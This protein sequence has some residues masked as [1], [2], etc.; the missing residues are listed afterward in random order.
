L[1]ASV[2]VTATVDRGSAGTV[3]DAQPDAL[4]SSRLYRWGVWVARHRRFVLIAG[5]F[6]LVLGTIL[7]PVLERALG[8]ANYQVQGSE[9]THAEQLLEQRFP[10]LGSEDDALVFYSRNRLASE[11]VY[12]RAIASVIA[13][14]RHQKHVLGVLGPYDVNAV[15]QIS[16]SEHAAITV[17]ALSGSIKQRFE[18]SRRLQAVATRAAGGSGVQTWLTGFSPL[19]RDLSDLGKTDTLRAETIGLPVALLILL[20]AVGSVVAAVLPI[21]MALAGLTLTYG[22]LA[23]L[24][25]TFR[26]DSGLL[27]IVTMIGLGIGIDYSLFVVSRFREHLVERPDA[28]DREES[29]RVADAVGMAIA[30]SGR[31]ILFSGAI[32]AVSLATMYLVHASTFQ[33]LAVGAVVVVVCML[34]TAMTLLP[35]G[36]A[37]LGFRIDRG[38]LPVRLRPANLRTGP[39]R[40]GWWAKWA[41]LMM[42]RPIV[43]AT[44][45]T[46]LLIVAALPALHLHYGVNLG[47]LQA[48]NTPSGKGE[49]VLAQSFSPGAMSPIQVVLNGGGPNSRPGPPVAAAQAMSEVL[50]RDNRVTATIERQSKSS[51]LL[52]VVPSVPIDTAA[53][54][55]LV[56]HIR[57]DLASRARAMG[58]TVF[59]G[60]LTAQTI[61][62]SNELRAKLPLI[63]A[64]IL[65][66]SFLLLLMVFR[67][68][69][70]PVKAIVM[71]LL[72][73]GAT[74]GIVVFVFQD[75]HGQHLLNFTGTGFIQSFLPL[76]VFAILFGLS[77]DYEVFLIGR[78]R[79]EWMKTHDNRLAVAT[80]IEHTARPITAAAAI[81]VAVFGCF[82][83]VNLLELKQIGFALAV[84][85]A[86]DATLIR[87]VLVPATMRLL[88]AWNW[89]LPTRLA[90]VLPGHED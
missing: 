21:L 62:L 2:G 73:I 35:A 34:F 33:E 48:S 50:E 14:M 27:A 31:T 45:A 1:G 22:V 40:Q 80:G 46:A 69:L 53:A 61:D 71:N 4:R 84:A 38:S 20:F 10:K 67:S 36:L 64:L 66:A 11:G 8:P 81:M 72:A 44:A 83:T 3:N 88:G 37:L 82:V 32:V 76:L 65:G 15:G 63:L 12:R 52:T 86:L 26:F 85:I 90:R 9:A 60:G 39:E 49:K 6:L 43:V 23:V 77:M 55:A 89:W 30:T 24:A 28:E 68:V 29:E 78:M 13:T 87:L 25:G 51:V 47:A 5:M 59:V 74:L 16:A 42:R 54:T 19:A 18:D 7:H 70:L 57:G 79:E 17:I 56:L 75:G 58:S 41:L